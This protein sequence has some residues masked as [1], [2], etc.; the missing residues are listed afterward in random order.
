MK[1]R[2]E[3]KAGS[4][5]THYVAKV[6]AGFLQL[7]MDFANVFATVMALMRLARHVMLTRAPYR[8]KPRRLHGLLA[9]R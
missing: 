2:P 3:E 4:H 7:M 6:G 8:L 1:I 5:M 9:T